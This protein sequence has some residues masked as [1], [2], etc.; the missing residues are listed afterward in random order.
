M[1]VILPLNE[2]A[3][4]YPMDDRAFGKGNAAQVGSGKKG[5]GPC[6]HSG[7]EGGAA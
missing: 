3:R 5:L 6:G 1:G 2:T 7:Q 4:F